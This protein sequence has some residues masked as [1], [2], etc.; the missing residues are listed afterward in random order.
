VLSGV[1]PGSN[2]GLPRVAGEG[3]PEQAQGLLELMMR[4][5]PIWERFELAERVGQRRWTLHLRDHVTIH[6]GADREAVAFAALTSADE[7]GALLTGHDIII[8][9]RTRG[10]ITVRPDKQSAGAP[11]APATQS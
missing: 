4:Y 2:V 5:P 11:S 9:L 6:L 10:R 3:A 1:K 8:D 7:L